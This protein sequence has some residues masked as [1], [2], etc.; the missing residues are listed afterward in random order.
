MTTTLKFLHG[1]GSSTQLDRRR[2]TTALHRHRCPHDLRPSGCAAW[3]SR[4]GSGS[5]VAASDGGDEESSIGDVKTG[6]SSERETRHRRLRRRVPPHGELSTAIAESMLTLDHHDERHIFST[7]KI[8]NIRCFHSG[9]TRYTFIF[10]PQFRIA[11][12]HRAIL[13]SIKRFTHHSGMQ[14]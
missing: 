7:Q 14:T 9:L 10:V 6:C 3:P 13:N 11:L 8:D 2:E 12:N 5:A 1:T 4:G